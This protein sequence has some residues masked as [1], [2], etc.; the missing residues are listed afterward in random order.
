M[1]E[2]EITQQLVDQT[3][4]EINRLVAEIETLSGQD[5]AP[6][7]FYGELCR[8]I[9]TALASQSVAMWMKT[10]AGNL[11]LQ[12]QINLQSIG[13]DSYE[14]TR[15]AHDELLRQS[16][17]HSKP[18]IL[19][20]YSGAGADHPGLTNPTGFLLAVCPIML[21]GMT[22]GMIEVFLDPN[23]RPS[24]YQGYLNFLVK[25]ASEGTRYLK[26]RQFRQIRTEQER[27]NQIEAFIRTVHGG[28][29][30]RQVAYLIANEGK[31]LIQCERLSVV[32]KR[33]R[34]GKVLAISGQEI[35]EK[36]SN[37]VQRM[38]K[39]SQRV[40]KHGE[41]LIYA[42]KI[43]EHWPRDI[44]QAL[45]RYLE[46]SGSKIVAIIPMPDEREFGVRGKSSSALVVEMIEDN[47]EPSE[48][49]ARIEVVARH[50]AS[51]LYNALEYHR[52]PFLFFWR[53]LGNSTELFRSHMLPKV[54]A[55]AAAITVLVL[56]LIFVPWPLR[57][58]GKG[59]LVPDIRRQVF[60]PVAGLVKD[61]KVEHDD[62]V[63]EGSVL[64]EMYS[65][66]LEQS[67][68]KLTGDLQAAEAQLQ[69]LR[70]QTPDVSRSAGSDATAELNGKI[71]QA[72]EQISGLKQQITLVQAQMETLKV[73]SPIQGRVLDWKPKEK[74]TQRPMQQGDALLEIAQV[75]GPWKLEIDFPENT[76]SHI[77]HARAK[78]PDRTLPCTFVLSGTPDKK[79]DGKLV[80]FGTQAQP[81]AEKENVVKGKV[82]LESDEDIQKLKGF[83]VRCKVDCGNYPVGYVLFR[84]LIDFI[85][86]YV[87]F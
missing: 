22:V 43:E 74:L 49:G 55:G 47:A 5:V 42:G 15:Q 79:Y 6:G 45:E 67:L 19:P 44:I 21:E 1:A 9:A 51:S 12:F 53:T 58:E 30:P 35:V 84:E 59:E 81:S 16:L 66:D 25:M 10:A 57:L 32:L 2:Q 54:I 78:N 23:R 26:N 29:N 65:P 72:Q 85:R 7:E 63:D 48:M 75:S 40:M 70:S 41:N 73:R 61:V 13:L 18:T 77:S 33:G 24:A 68:I 80:E 14:A 38:A 37:L 64:V 4:R 82:T 20:P 56:G 28:L 46:E 60:A 27:W 11:Q 86:E 52:I 39:L 17:V 83:E 87:F 8:R 62:P 36:R 31:R 50:G 3:R 71:A 34:R 69:G 76:A